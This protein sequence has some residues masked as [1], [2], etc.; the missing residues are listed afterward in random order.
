MNHL[1]EELAKVD[2]VIL[3]R[4]STEFSQAFDVAIERR[5]FVGVLG[6]VPDDGW[7]LFVES[8]LGWWRRLIGVTD[9]R[10]H[11]LIVR[12]IERI[13][14]EDPQISNMRLYRDAEQWNRGADGVSP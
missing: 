14:R 13:L 5:V 8:T 9:E 10:E 4:G 1:E 12:A 7:L 2:V 3:E 6:P 11:G